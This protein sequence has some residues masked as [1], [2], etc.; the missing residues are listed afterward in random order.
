MNDLL[1]AQSGGGQAFSLHEKLLV[2][3]FEQELKH[4]L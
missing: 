2:S 4:R 1:A 3:L